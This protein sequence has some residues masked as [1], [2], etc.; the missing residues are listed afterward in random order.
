MLYL[1]PVS[2]GKNKLPILVTISLTLT[3]TKG[4]HIR[5]QAVKKK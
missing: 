1:F 2:N 3:N 5:V 4:E